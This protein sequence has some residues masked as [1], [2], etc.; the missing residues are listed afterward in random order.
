MKQFPWAPLDGT[1]SSN[2]G[3]ANLL[4]DEPRHLTKRELEA[5]DN[6][7]A[8][9]ST[10]RNDRSDLLSI[11]CQFRSFTI[12]SF[13]RAQKRYL[14]HLCLLAEHRQVTV[15]KFNL[16]WLRNHS[17]RPCGSIECLRLLIEDMQFNPFETFDS[18]TSLISPFTIILEPIYLYL[19]ELHHRFLLDRQMKFSARLLRAFHDLISKQIALFTYLVTHC[20]FQPTKTDRIRLSECCHYIEEV[21][22]PTEQYLPV[23][24]IMFNLDNLLTN[25]QPDLQRQ[26]LS[27]KEICRLNFRQSLREQRHVLVQIENRLL[28]LSASHKKYLK[29]LGWDLFLSFLLLRIFEIKFR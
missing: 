8:L 18:Q 13:T 9:F 1:S 20:C 27:L 2:Q 10:I 14:F 19:I 6:E 24:R 16:K 17:L 25:I 21:F 26:C 7:I 5:Y 28:N 23:R 4:H 3:H 11:L 15:D 22:H 29:C 12:E